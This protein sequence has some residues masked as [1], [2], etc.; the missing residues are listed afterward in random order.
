[1]ETEIR[2]CLSVAKNGYLVYGDYVNKFRAIPCIY[3]GCKPVQRRLLYALSYQARGTKLKSATIVGETC[4]K[5]HPHGDSSTYGALVTLVRTGIVKGYGNWGA[6]L[7][8]SLGPAAMRYTKVALSDEMYNDLFELSDHFR[9]VDSELGYKEPE[10][11]TCPLPIALMAGSSGIGLGCSTN[12]PSLD[13]QSMIDAL[14][15][16]DPSLLKISSKNLECVS[17]EWADLWEFGRGK[18]HYSY[19]VEKSWSQSRDSEIVTITGDGSIFKPRLAAVFQKYLNEG[20][21]QISD[22]SSDMIRLVIYKTKHIRKI[23]IDQ[24]FKLAQ[25][26]AQKAFTYT[27]NVYDPRAGGVRQVGLKEWLEVCRDN[28]LQTHKVYVDTNVTKRSRE[29]SLLEKTPKIIANL[30]KQVPDSETISTFEI[31]K[32]ELKTVENF[33][34]KYHRPE[35]VNDRIKMLQSQIKNFESKRKS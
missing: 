31:T 25:L 14:N 15:N 13:K 34:M 7:M 24:I 26:C 33:P 4:G 3:D 12:I 35:V 27:L 23:N 5:L 10:W 8:Q 32:D 16:N 2:N 11:L 18:I 1:M 28:Y 6:S 17:A 19:K 30:I 21:I 9:Y 20:L 29:I 22:E